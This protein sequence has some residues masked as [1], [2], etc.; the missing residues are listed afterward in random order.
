M[1]AVGRASSSEPILC[2]LNYRGDT[3]NPD[4]KTAL[5]GKGVVYDCGGLSLK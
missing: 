2:I 1:H 4:N 5:V 3:A